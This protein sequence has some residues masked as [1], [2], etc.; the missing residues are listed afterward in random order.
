M[1][2]LRSLLTCFVVAMLAA[3][4]LQPTAPESEA[5]I[6]PQAAAWQL[7]GA[8][9]DVSKPAFTSHAAVAVDGS[10]NPVVAWH[11]L[12]AQSTN[13][14]VK[15]W[16]GTA[17]SQLG[18]LL[19][20]KANEFAY[21]PAIALDSAGNPVVAW[22]EDAG[23]Q[24]A[25]R[26]I[27]AK[28]WNGSSWVQLGS[29]IDAA[30]TTKGAQNASLAI[31]NAGNPVVAFF[32]DVGVGTAFND[33]VY[34]KRWNGTSWVQLGNA[35]DI[36]TNRTADYPSLALDNTG[37]PIV[38][39][40]EFDG[41]SSNSNIY[42][43]RWNGSVWVR[44]GSAALDMTLATPARL[45]SLDVDSTGKPVVAWEE[46]FSSN[47]NIYVKRWTG[48]TWSQVG[49]APLDINA[50]LAA[51]NAALS[52]DGANNPVVTWQ[53][54]T[55][56]NLYNV[57]IKRWNG[58]AWATVGVN[59]LETKLSNHAKES[60]LAL[61]G[62][63]NPVV[64]WEECAQ[65]NFNR[66]CNSNSDIY[67]KR[68]TTNGWQPLGSAVDIMPDNEAL[69]SS[70]A[71]KSTDRPVVVWQ[72]LNNIYVKEWTGTTWVALGSKL[73]TNSGS[74]PV[75]AMRSDDKPV[76]AWS[77]NGNQLFVKVWNGS[78]WQAQGVISD[79]TMNSFALAVGSNNNPIVAY[80]ALGNDPEATNLYV[81]RW[82]GTAWVGM[83]GS[84]TVPPLDIELN[85]NANVP[86]LAVDS[87]GKPAVA[88]L[89]FDNLS[90][91]IFVK[92]WTGSAWVQLGMNLETFPANNPSLD[93]DSTGKP[94]VAWEERVLSNSNIY[95]KRWSGSSWLN[96]GTGQAVEKLG[97]DNAYEPVLQLRSD[98]NPVVALTQAGFSSFDIYVRRWDAAQSKWVD[99]GVPV[100]NNTAMSAQRPSLV[101]Q[102]NNNPTLSWD[103]FDGGSSNVYVRRF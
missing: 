60:A 78:S 21:E 8:S 99:V 81:K 5:T 31:D 59:P 24:F 75:I 28:R 13:I 70:L 37:N 1:K 101:L 2:K 27:Y 3:C 19:D 41:N 77:E 73:N 87:T 23:G 55:T 15:R 97:S 33:N 76:V 61:D 7:L 12:D 30:G 74:T 65:V 66:T 100:D 53:E 85:R 102:N 4:N 93:I 88:W 80:S 62:A 48:T 89:E 22:E 10:G 39:W 79:R 14:Y 92:R 49:T 91:S 56:T 50:T 64:A 17:W 58:A 34:V 72:E 6:E 94:V 47:T 103:E 68:F 25:D 43:K 20:V 36:N 63:G 82:T 11:E 42:V 90:Q 35:L 44:L 83:N 29:F 26:H 86:S 51:D 96:Y 67:V 46:G 57:Y 40:E 45:P 52:L 71:R 32:E 18:G 98:N 9:L 84:S 54:Y 38:A 16:T 69:N 95:V